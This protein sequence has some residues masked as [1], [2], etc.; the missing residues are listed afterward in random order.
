MIDEIISFAY[1]SPKCTLKRLRREFSSKGKDIPSIKAHLRNENCEFIDHD[2]IIKMCTK[3]SYENNINDLI[4]N[5]WIQ[6]QYTNYI[7]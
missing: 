5:D 7:M 3:P 2:F 6:E 1:Q 4:L